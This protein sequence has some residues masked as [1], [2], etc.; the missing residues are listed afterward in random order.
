MVALQG[1]VS[2]RRLASVDDSGAFVALYEIKADDLQAVMNNLLK[3]AGRG[4]LRMS[5]AL[6][7]EPPPVMRLLGVTAA[8]EPSAGTAR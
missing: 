5:S 7:S 4:E 2:A 6:Q 8:H 3:A 1:F